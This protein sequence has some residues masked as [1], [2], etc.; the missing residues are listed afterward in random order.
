MANWSLYESKMNIEGSSIRERQIN[1][2]QDNILND[3]QN[4]PSYR[5]AYINGSNDYKEVHVVETQYSFVK[6]ILTKPGDELFTGDILEF[7]N[8]KWLCTEVNKSLRVYDVGKVYLCN[9]TLKLYKNHI[10]YEIPAVVESAVR[11]Y[12]LG[13]EENKYIST[14]SSTIIVRIPANSITQQIKRNDVYKLGVQNYSVQDINDILEPGLIILKLEYEQQ[15]QQL[16]NYTLTILNG[17][18]IQISQSQQLTINVE[19]KDGDNIIPTPPLLYSSSDE[20]IATID[21]SGI[22]TI[23][24]VGIVEF[25]VSLVGD[26]NTK[27]V[28][29]VEIVADET[30]NF[31]V[32]INGSST[33]TKN[34]TSNYA[35]VFKNNGNVIPMQSEFYLTGDDGVSTTNLAEIVSQ[36]GENNTC[37]IKGLNLGY[38]KLWVK[39]VDGSIVSDP[40]RIQIKNL[41]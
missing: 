39:S 32:E 1:A 11:L 16:P 24:D 12:Q 22:V 18:N 27:D 38:V 20:T 25:T 7:D 5:Q 35:C 23:L 21:E 28:I 3:F 31:T 6:N 8:N 14:P 9:N 15:E 4:S 2:I 40:L 26:E 13:I 41:F 30:D 17:D 33:I 10:L 37:V 29:Q 34:Y 36:D 19:V